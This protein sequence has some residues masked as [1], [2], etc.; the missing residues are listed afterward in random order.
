V[1]VVIPAFNEQDAVA[2]VI[3]AVHREGYPAL[4]VD[5]GSSDRTSAVATAAGAI[6]LRL[7]VNLG[8]GGA[9]RCGFRYAVSHGYRVAVQCDADGQHDAAEIRKLLDV[10]DAEDAQ[11]VIGSRFAADDSVYRVGH[12]RRLAM[13]YLARMASKRTGV[14][15][16]DA[17]SGFRAI[18]DGL[19]GAFAS[20]YPAEY[21]ESTESLARAG[22]A[23]YRVR[24]VAV[25][26]HERAVG[27]SSASPI[28]SAWYLLR[29]VA[30]LSLQRYRHPSGRRMVRNTMW[31]QQVA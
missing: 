2:D 1:L 29:V 7:P 19:L 21:M 4:V 28:A 22:D 27:V 5:D 18:G 10:M 25:R 20:A 13:R 26:M 14:V 23:G 12:T 9:L 6:V 31:E 11:L 30:A 15:I 24:E 16:T 17:S 3:A 8:I